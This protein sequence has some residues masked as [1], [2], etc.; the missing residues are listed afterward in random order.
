MREDLR[1]VST[2]LDSAVNK[3][4]GRRERKRKRKGRGR[5][6]EEEEV[7]IYNRKRGKGRV[8]EGRECV[9]ES[10]KECQ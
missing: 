4:G 1:G 6:R 9:G 8:R 10:K 3:R 2:E 7:G 5:E